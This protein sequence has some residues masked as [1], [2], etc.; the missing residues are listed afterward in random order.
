M[1]RMIESDAPSRPCEQPDSLKA[2]SSPPL[3]LGGWAVAMVVLGLAAFAAAYGQAPLYYSNQNQYFLHGLAAAGDGLLS[4]DWLA[5]TSDPTPVFSALIA[6]TAR[7]LHPWLFYGYYALLMALYAGALLLLFWV[8]AGPDFAEQR[9]PIFLM[10]LVLVHSAAARWLSFRLLGKDYPWYLQSGV[11]G[12]Y[13][14]GAM[15]QPSTFGVLLVAAVALFA[16]GWDITAV[17]CIA[18]GA[19]VH[20]TYLLPGALLTAGLMTA[21]LFEG[22]AQ[23]GVALGALALALVLPVTA[24]VAVNFASATPEAAEAQQILAHERIPHHCLVNLWLDPIAG[25]QIAWIGLGLVLSWKTRVFP[26]LAVSIGLAVALTAWQVASDS[27]TLALLFPWRISAVLT[28]IAT[29]IVLSRLV[30]LPWLPLGNLVVA[31]LSAISVAV[32]AAAGVYICVG[33]L[34]FQ[35]NEEERPLYDYVRDHRNPGDVYLV[36]VQIPDLK[37]TVRG[38]ASSDFKPAAAKR[39]DT[40]VIPIDLQRFRLA[41][42]VPIFVDFKA[43][44]YKDVDVIEWYHRLKLAKAI[45]LELQHGPVPDAVSKLHEHHITHIV[46]PAGKELDDPG[47]TRLPLASTA[48]QLY[49]VNRA[50]AGNR[51]PAWLDGPRP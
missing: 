45:Q 32:L 23:R 26:V 33:G 51:R 42:E 12:Q 46:L 27:N 24:Y 35:S 41:A 16:R 28:P 6:V 11:A 48:Y 2:S 37:H 29:A 10:L 44:P 31:V 18:I 7:Y 1:S 36:P 5:N 34:A 47:L 13:V 50:P 40:Q 19:T 21:L 9:W 17:V 15:F 4:E 25:L 20:S 43:I 8:L 30:A 14:L 3:R 22:R 49:R 38:S 39:N